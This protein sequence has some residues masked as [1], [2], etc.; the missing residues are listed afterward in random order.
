[1][2]SQTEPKGESVHIELQRVQTWLFAVPRLKAMVG[3]NALLGETL[4]IKLPELAKTPPSGSAWQLQGRTDASSYAEKQ[5][6]DPLGPDD[7]P[8]DDAK[9]GILARDGGHFEAQFAHGAA[10]FAKAAGELLEE[11]LP[12]L[13]F[14][15]KVNGE[16]IERGGVSLSCELPVLAPCSWSGRGLASAVLKQGNDPFEVSLD[17]QKRHEAAR[18]ASAGKATD[19]SQTKDNEKAQDLA[20]LLTRQTGLAELKLADDF[21][22]LTGEDYLAVIHADGNGVGLEASGKKSDAEKA[23]FFH[24]NRGLLRIALKHA[25]DEA[26]KGTK[27]DQTCPLTV[28][29]LGGDDVLVVC[30]ASLAL[31]FVRD[32]CKKL[33]EIQAGLP[34]AA[35]RLTLGVGVVFSRPS[36]P[37]HRL[38]EVAEKLASSAKRLYRGMGTANRA[39]VVDWASYTTAWADDPA[40]VRARDWICGSGSTLRILSRR[41]LRVVGDGHHRLAGLIL[42]AEK[43]LTAPRSQLHHL[44]ETLRQGKSLAELAFEEL[45]PSTKRA[46]SSAGV[47][48]VWE[49]DKDQTLLTSI[50]DLVEVLEIPRLGVKNKGGPQAVSES[51][52]SVATKKEAAH[53]QAQ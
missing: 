44:V 46:L 51:T 36:V 45:S 24:R 29:M 31:P 10:E 25:M 34:A 18:R 22:D 52:V 49:E 32:L 16:R 8:V 39:S 15:V 9:A 23:Q 13:Q 48:G 12:G 6:D 40:E 2:T 1:M 43:L 4:R 28:L 27:A 11:E 5:D 41:P 7:D 42:A 47:T 30:R 35:F 33:E 14:S 37:F 53:E 17:A 3:A 20:S 38:H 21:D 19:G 50:L 26:A